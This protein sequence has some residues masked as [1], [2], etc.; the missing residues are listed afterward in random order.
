MVPN[1]WIARS[2]SSWTTSGL[3]RLPWTP[4]AS[5]PKRATS[6][7]ASS[8]TSL[9]RAGVIAHA[10]SFGRRRWRERTRLVEGPPIQVV[11][12]EPRAVLCEQDRGL[13]SDAP[14]R[15]RDDGDVPAEQRAARGRVGR[16]DHEVPPDRV[17]APV[18]VLPGHD[19]WCG[20]AMTEEGDGADGR[21]FVGSSPQLVPRHAKAPQKG[22]V[23]SM[24]MTVLKSAGFL[25]PS[26]GFNSAGRKVNSERKVNSKTGSSLIHHTAESAPVHTRRRRTTQPPRVAPPESARHAQAVFPHAPALQFARALSRGPADVRA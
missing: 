21:R 14:P 9:C 5:P 15:P 8:H 4:T 20:N 6:L 16:C 23:K 2:T 26:V 12:H 18:H 7:H 24:G 19:S 25:R 11:E 13:P 10:V 22:G 1:A 17:D 3:V